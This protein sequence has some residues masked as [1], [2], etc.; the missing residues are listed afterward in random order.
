M[1]DCSI[2]LQSIDDSH[3]KKLDCDCVYIYHTNCIDR[4]LKDHPSC[5]TCRKGFSSPPQVRTP[6]TN[7]VSQPQ[8]L[9]VNNNISNNVVPYNT[10]GLGRGS[11]SLGFA[12]YN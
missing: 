12:P 3:K 6:S 1:S 8:W 9:R 10:S 5:P 4:W 11:G 2:C 7:N